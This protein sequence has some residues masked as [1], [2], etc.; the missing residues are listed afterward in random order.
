M[1]L[2]T[3]F[4]CATSAPAV[5][6]CWLEGT[7]EVLCIPPAPFGENNVSLSELSQAVWGSTQ[8]LLLMIQYSLSTGPWIV[9]VMLATA[10]NV[11][12]PYQ[13]LTAIFYSFAFQMLIT[14]P[15]FK[16]I[17]SLCLI[18]LRIIMTCLFSGVDHEGISTSCGCV[19]ENSSLSQHHCCDDHRWPA[20]H[21]YREPRR[22]NMSLG[23]FIRLTGLC[24]LCCSLLNRLEF[25]LL[26]LAIG[27]SR[28][29]LI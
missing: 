2:L 23:S 7:G 25:Y 21:S 12:M 1:S 6:S 24:L 16:V 11:S 15:L 27:L 26:V 18:L 3:P 13:C 8:L 10:K 5:G 17:F 19:G 20:D 14:F 9:S 28:L 29:V 22:T 4:S